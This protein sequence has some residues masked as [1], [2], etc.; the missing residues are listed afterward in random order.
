MSQLHENIYNRRLQRDEPKLKLWRYAGLMLT[1]KC[2]A[3]C[4]FCYYHC[5]PHSSGL[6]PIDTALEV[7]QSLT[8]IAGENAKLHIT[9]GEPFLYFDH[10]ADLM[11]RAKNLNLT[12]VNTIET[13]AFWA[14][15]IDKAHDVLRRMHA[16][17]LT[18]LLVSASMFHNEFIPFARTQNCI[19]A[20]VDVFG[21]GG[22]LVWTEQQ[23]ELVARLPDHDKTHTL[24]EF[25]RVIGIPADSPQLPRLY[26]LTPG[27]RVP[28]AL[29]HCYAAAPAQSF[30]GDRCERE[31]LST[32]HFHIDHFGNLFTG[33]CA[34]IAPGDGE[35]LHPPISEDTFPVFCQLC[36]EG[37]FGLM[38]MAA[39]EF[40]YVPRDDGYISKCDL[41]FDIRRTL[42]TT[43]TFPE[44]RP[45]NYYEC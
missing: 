28:D 19:D 40:G 15:S 42:R 27:G 8:A 12:P 3:S 9:G 21:H 10:L 44:L 5:G 37:P 30:R 11:H 17:G 26:G 7:W 18:G 2:P 36:E 23:R 39:D 33:L 13:N 43:G 45:A 29:R 14:T 24:E 1:Y 6:M 16:A 22:L 38:Q 31:L 34:G 41:C 35:N 20:A 32:T 4:E 25:C